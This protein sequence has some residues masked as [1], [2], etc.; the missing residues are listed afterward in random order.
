MIEMIEPRKFSEILDLRRKYD[1]TLAGHHVRSAEAYILF[2]LYVVQP[3]AMYGL[4]EVVLFNM[5]L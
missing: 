3:R 1:W 5:Q 2:S 4:F